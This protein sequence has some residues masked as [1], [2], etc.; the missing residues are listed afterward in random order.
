MHES[1]YGMAG[2]KALNNFSFE[3]VE[4]RAFFLEQPQKYSSPQAPT[5]KYVLIDWVGGPE[6]KYLGRGHD[7]DVQTERNDVRALWPSAD[8]LPS[9]SNKLSQ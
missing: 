6:G 3:S 5:E 4:M 8:I 1:F 9:G 2:T 7:H